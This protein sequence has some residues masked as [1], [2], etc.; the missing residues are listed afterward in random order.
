MNSR[1]TGRILVVDDQE[2]W[3]AALTNL[4]SKEGHVVE[5]AACFEDAAERISQGVFDLVVLDVRLVDT[6]IYDVRG[7]ELLRL[8]KEQKV[9]P[10]A[11]VLTG[12]PE[13]IRD[14]ILEQYGA[15]VLILKVPPDTKKFDRAG[16]KGQVRKLLLETRVG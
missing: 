7:L 15:D 5:V 13:S 9:A 8:A 11:I 4:L 3:R 14:G 2:N 6:D 1:I 16:F 10:R 12:Y